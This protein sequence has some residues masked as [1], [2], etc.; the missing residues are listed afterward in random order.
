MAK[1]LH[2]WISQSAYTMLYREWKKPLNKAVQSLQLLREWNANGEIIS[3]VSDYIN[4]NL[5]VR[6]GDT[7]GTSI[8]VCI[9]RV[10]FLTP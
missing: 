7:S 4:L 5:L 1:L 8:N 3:L 9:I 6:E 2:C 10:R